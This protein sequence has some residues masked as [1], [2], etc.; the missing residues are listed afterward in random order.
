MIIRVGKLVN[1]NISLL[2]RKLRPQKERSFTSELQMFIYFFAAKKY[3]QSKIM[4]N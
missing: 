3:K 2:K 1:K 4:P